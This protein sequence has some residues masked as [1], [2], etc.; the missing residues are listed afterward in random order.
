LFCEILD[1]GI[2]TSAYYWDG[3]AGNNA[4]W[5][6]D[7]PLWAAHWTGNNNGQIPPG[8]AVPILPHDFG[9]ADLWQFTSKGGVLVGWPGGLDVNLTG[10]FTAVAPPP[11]GQTYAIDFLRADPAA[12]RVIRRADGSGEDVWDLPTSTGFCRVKNSQQGEW[13]SADGRT[14][15]RDTSP[16]PDSTGNARLYVQTTGGTSGGKIAPDTATMGQIYVFYSDVQFYAKSNCQPLAENSGKNVPSTFQLVDVIDDYEFPM[17]GFVV[18]RLY[19]TM[20]TGEKQ[21]YAIKDGRKLGWAGGG[22]SQAGNTWAGE[23]NE[24]YFDRNIPQ[25]EPNKYCS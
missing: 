16:A 17:T 25:L 22:A 24:L 4:A 1:C 8:T 3:I 10:P 18:D 7:Y 23:L 15:Y 6:A 11:T 9:Q 20:Q 21:L 13:Y 12:W 2:Y 5:W 19:I 14:R